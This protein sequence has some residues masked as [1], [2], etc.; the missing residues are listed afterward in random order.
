MDYYTLTVRYSEKELRD[1]ICIFC[2][3]CHLCPFCKNDGDTIMCWGDNAPIEQILSLAE[4]H[5]Y[6][7]KKEESE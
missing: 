5:G 7:F 4:E 2:S 1:F 3:T 6:I